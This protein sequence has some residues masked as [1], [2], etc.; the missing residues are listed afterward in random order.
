MTQDKAEHYHDK[1]KYIT[2]QQA[3]LQFDLFSMQLNMWY[4]VQYSLHYNKLLKEVLL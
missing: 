2:P 1:K 4:T 3:L